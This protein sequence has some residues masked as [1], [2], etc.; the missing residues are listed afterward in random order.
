MKR[1]FF[2]ILFGLALLAGMAASASA[3]GRD[4][5][6]TLPA[7][8]V[9]EAVQKILP[10]TIPAQISGVQGDLI[11]ESLS[12]LAVNGNVIAVSG[13]LAAR[14]MHVNANVGGKP[15]QLQLGEARLPVSCDLLT[16]FDKASGKLFFTPRFTGQGGDDAGFS[17]L[18]GGLSRREYPLELDALERLDFQIGPRTVSFA[19]RPTDIYGQDNALTFALQPRA[20]QP[21]AKA[22][23]SR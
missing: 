11:L 13:V 4:I 23:K 22:K 21:R 2:H 3:A 6:V 9:L 18:L 7:E 20:I 10:L 12:R 5:T 17:Q 1:L 16:R 14:N 19:L 8:T 15:F